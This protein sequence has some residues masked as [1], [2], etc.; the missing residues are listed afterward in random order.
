MQHCMARAAHAW[1]SRFDGFPSTAGTTA[2]V[3]I[4]RGDNCWLANVGDSAA[5]LS[6]SGGN[7][8]CT[9]RHPA[10]RHVRAHTHR[11]FRP[12]GILR[13]R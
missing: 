2:T 6:T 13:C 5:F 1:P 12:R 11:Q 4:V 8:V 7:E 10:R 9:A 3:C